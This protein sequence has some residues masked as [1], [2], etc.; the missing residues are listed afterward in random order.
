MTN[1]LRQISDQQMRV[2]LKAALE[3][4]GSRILS[5]YREVLELWLAQEEAKAAIREA[6]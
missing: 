1:E 2:M 3:D 6:A 5:A 4:K